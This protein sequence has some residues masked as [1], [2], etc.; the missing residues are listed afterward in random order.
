MVIGGAV[1]GYYA[2]TGA[3]TFGIYPIIPEVGRHW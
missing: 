2:V 3:H 1:M